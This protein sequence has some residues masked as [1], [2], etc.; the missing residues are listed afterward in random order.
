MAPFDPQAKRK[1]IALAP[2][3]ERA[4]QSTERVRLNALVEL[5][6][7]RNIGQGAHGFGILTG[8]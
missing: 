1:I 6:S 5:K 3:V 7:F 4:N 2:G 8:R